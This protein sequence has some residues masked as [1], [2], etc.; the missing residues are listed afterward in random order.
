MQSLLSFYSLWGLFF[1]YLFYLGVVP[2]T[3]TMA[4]FILLISFIFQW[5]YPGYYFIYPWK[6]TPS[7]VIGDIIT[8][9][10]P[11]L[12]I[13]KSYD[14][15]VLIFSFLLYSSFFELNHIIYVY[16]DPIGYAEKLLI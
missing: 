7:L 8:H 3:Y 6:Y 5:I 9:Y 11:V 2:N 13:Q 4:V 14:L 15:R 12:Y 16:Q 10:L 1:H